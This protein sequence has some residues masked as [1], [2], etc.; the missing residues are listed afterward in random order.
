[1]IPGQD[2]SNFHHLDDDDLMDF[3]SS[4]DIQERYSHILPSARENLLNGSPSAGVTAP[5]TS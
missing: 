4:C 5:S 1:M 3:G 2:I